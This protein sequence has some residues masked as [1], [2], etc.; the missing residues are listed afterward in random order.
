[1]LNHKKSAFFSLT[2][3]NIVC[4]SV[5]LKENISNS[6]LGKFDIQIIHN[7]IDTEIFKPAENKGK[8]RNKYD[9]PLDKKIIIFSASNLKDKS[10]GIDH[11][12][13]TAKLLI[14]KNY[15][16]VG[17]GNGKLDETS[18]IKTLG[19]IYD[20]KEL[21]EI[22]ALSDIFCFA[23]SAETFLLSA[24][25]ALSCGIPVVGF[26][27]PVVRELVNSEVGIL[28]KNDSVSL[29][30]SI[31]NL[32]DNTKTLA[33]MSKTGRKLIE[34]NYT[35]DVFYAKYKESYSKIFK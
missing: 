15:L 4:P 11:I 32:L 1:M 9:L 13:E 19:Y 14:N 30:E 31:A 28:T 27:L 6:F 35:K 26:D 7:S 8:L 2:K 23:S 25:E 34:V 17:L 21:S 12:I 29:S 16:F 3:M 18:N 20:K 5:W 10:K 33:T 22:Y 24:A